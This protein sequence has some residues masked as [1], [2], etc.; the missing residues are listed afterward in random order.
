MAKNTLVNNTNVEIYI[1]VWLDA[2]VNTNEE[3]RKAQEQ[4]RT[5][6]S[7]LKA[8]ES[9][10]ECK[11]YV[12]SLSSQERVLLIVSGRFG[13]ELI[14]KIHSLRQV[15]S[16]YV[17]CKDKIANEKWAIHFMKVKLM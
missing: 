4:L 17:Y 12:R 16:I 3:N 5:I 15:V 10:D 2:E 7:R 9:R 11:K 1:T 13:E 8:F 14:P 6:I